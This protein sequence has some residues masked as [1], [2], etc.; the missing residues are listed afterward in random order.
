M[1]RSVQY[2]FH[3]CTSTLHRAMR[4]CELRLAHALNDP[5]THYSASA[6]G[7]KG[8]KEPV[9][10]TQR[11]V[12]SCARL[13]AVALLVVFGSIAAHGQAMGTSIDQFTYDAVDLQT[14]QIYFRLP[15]R[16]RPGMLATSAEITGN[17]SLATLYNSTW[18]TTDYKTLFNLRVFPSVAVVGYTTRTKMSCGYGHADN[19][20]YGGLYVSDGMGLP[21]M[22]PSSMYYYYAPDGTCQN[23]NQS[24]YTL[25]GTGYYAVRWVS[26]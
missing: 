21:H 2:S 20:R 26:A 17:T 14:L 13:W 18:V 7:R 6:P 22:L 1:I 8:L 25:D 9:H 10:I 3:G 4:W 16:S 5:A 12:C 23:T 15:A 24:G 11:F 19:Y